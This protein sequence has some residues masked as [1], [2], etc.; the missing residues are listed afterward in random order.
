MAAQG[1]QPVSAGNLATALD[2]SATADGTG[3]K[4]LCAD[5]LRA[6]LA[7][8][9]LFSDVLWEGSSWNTSMDRSTG[10][11]KVDAP[12]ADYV[13]LEFHVDGS[14]GTQNVQ[15]V[16]FRDPSDDY[17]TLYPEYIS[18]STG[19]NTSSSYGLKIKSTSSAF[20]ILCSCPSIR[21]VIGYRP[22]NPS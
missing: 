2:V 16:V 1:N 14:Y 15:T 9:L 20:R 13:T 4:P 11:A 12:L 3:S 5:N 19:S 10:G 21:K 22:V 6:V 8:G 17:P 18:V 7:A